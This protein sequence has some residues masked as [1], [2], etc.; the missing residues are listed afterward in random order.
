MLQ[1]GHPWNSQH[2]LACKVVDDVRFHISFNQKNP[3]SNRPDHMAPV[4]THGSVQLVPT[5]KGQELTA[6][7][8]FMIKANLKTLYLPKVGSRNQNP[9]T[10]HSHCPSPILVPIK[11]R[12]AKQRIS[13]VQQ[14][15][16]QCME[17]HNRRR[18][19]AQP[20]NGF[21]GQTAAEEIFTVVRRQGEPV[22]QSTIDPV[23]FLQR[24]K[25]CLG[26]HRRSFFLVAA[27]PAG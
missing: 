25:A 11:S 18:L 13:L 3:L 5:G 10:P 15:L 24:R 2:R 12:D 17:P 14:G 8:H 19:I 21:V 23:P 26:L 1:R 20:F 6:L 7:F 22:E 27:F 16:G 9:P 4:L